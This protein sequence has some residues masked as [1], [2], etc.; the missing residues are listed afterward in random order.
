MPRRARAA[1]PSVGPNDRTFHFC[2]SERLPYRTMAC[3]FLWSGLLLGLLHSGARHESVFSN[4]RLAAHG[5]KSQHG[6]LYVVCFTPI[7]LAL[8]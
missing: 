8:N 7:S 1:E 4:A 6:F 5:G 3:C 2:V